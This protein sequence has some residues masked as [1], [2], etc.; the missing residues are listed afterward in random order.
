[1]PDS[2]MT[3]PASGP[4]KEPSGPHWSKDYV[5]HLRTIHFSLIALSLAAL[6][7]ALSP[8]PD[9]IK[10]ARQQINAIGEVARTWKSEWLEEAAEQA[11]DNYKKE[12]DPTD[13]TIRD[14]RD[15]AGGSVLT[16]LGTNAAT[17]QLQRGKP[18]TCAVQFATPNW[19]IVGPVRSYFLDQSGPPPPASQDIFGS[20]PK[21]LL[22]DRISSIR[23]TSLTAPKTLDQ[24]KSLW[25][26]L[27]EKS[28]I[29]SPIR[30][31]MDVYTDA[32]LV[33]TSLV[34]SG[35]LQWTRV[36]PDTLAT[37]CVFNFE[38][39]SLRDS[40]KNGLPGSSNGF[41]YFFAE[42]FGLSEFTPVNLSNQITFT[43]QNGLM[44]DF[45]S[46]KPVGGSFE[47][48]FPELNKITK[49][50]QTLEIDKFDAILEAEQ[51]RTGESFEA[52]GVKFPA[53]ATT[54]WG[55]LVILAVQLYFWVHLQ[56]LSRKLAPD[57]PGWEVAFIGMYH[58]LPS[59]LVYT[60]SALA[61][62]IGAVTALGIRG[63]F[64]G[65]FH[66][67]YWLL[68]AS[69]IILSMTLAGLAW[70]SAPSRPVIKSAK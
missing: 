48:S 42:P 62:P 26:M 4:H 30:L 27:N 67:L 24:F 43:P 12:L 61:L 69:G 25:N 31:S 57:D 58:S 49:N 2:E 36:A 55:I 15:F 70:R 8:N 52:F 47:H 7:L 66:W 54:R 60:F 39:R 14:I 20:E 32:G 16:T 23:R 46:W 13:S 56:E 6:V 9:E 18:S 59:R 68:L 3:A 10:K 22:Q 5:E 40:V 37:M 35:K 41:A 64:V 21:P 34:N 11:I 50:Y 1:M 51:N 63:L 44:Q 28:G 65:S 53:E 33:E 38:L 19:I 45:G 17:I 29:L